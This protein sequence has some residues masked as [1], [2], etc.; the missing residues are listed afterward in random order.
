MSHDPFPSKLAL[1]EQF[2]NRFKERNVLKDNI[3]A[4]RH[5]VLV[6][7]RRYGKTS[8]V[9]YVLSELKLPY[10]YI[11]FFLAYD[12]RAIVKRM[13]V[14]ISE[15]VSSLMSFEE[16]TFKSIQALFGKFKATMGAHGFQIEMA[17]D[18]GEVDA[19]DQIYSALIALATLAKKENKKITLFI[20]EFQNITAAKTSKSIQGAI[21]HVAQETNDLMMIFSGS[22][23]RLL[24]EMFDDRS[25]PLYMLCDKINLDRMTSMDYQPH[26]QQ[27][28]LERW[29]RS[30]P[31][32]VLTRI[33]T[34]TEL[35][36]FY[37]NFLCHKLWKNSTCP[38]VCDVDACWEQCLDDENRRIRS[39]LEKLTRNQQEVMKA[40]AI[41][42]THEPTSHLFSTQANVAPSSLHQTIKTLLDN[43]LIYKVK[44]DDT[45]VSIL[46][47][48]QIRVLDPLIAF[49]L[50]KYA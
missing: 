33:L 2:C 21:R 37:V 47:T 10:V 27:L 26:L 39:E 41:E 7:P 6:S 31:V 49:S 18:H 20:D 1:G 38:T 48:G 16:K 22:N 46:R 11:D 3:F 15:M 4:S 43:D 13:L 42:P 29:S 9:H 35:H 23:R 24:L 32:M 40:L 34:C 14:G 19:V 50:K 45:M 44:K 30:L 5:T 36:P 8:L 17:Y 28:A 25:M 12:E